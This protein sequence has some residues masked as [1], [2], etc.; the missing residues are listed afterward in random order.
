MVAPGLVADAALDEVRRLAAEAV[1]V[2]RRFGPTNRA[3]L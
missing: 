3:R 1:D 2:A